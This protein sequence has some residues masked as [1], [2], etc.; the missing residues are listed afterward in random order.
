MITLAQAQTN[1]DALLA[2]PPGDIGSVN[3]SGRTVTYR[4][5]AELQSLINYWTRIVA[6]LKRKADGQS[7]HSV[8]AAS[9]RSNQ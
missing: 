7:R 6:G 2:L 4:S 8:A 1:L 5:A 9:F 3:I